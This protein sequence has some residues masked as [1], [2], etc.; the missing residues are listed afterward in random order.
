[1]ARYLLV[2]D[3]DRP[4][5]SIEGATFQR[6]GKVFAIR[7]HNVPTDKKR[8]PQTGSRNKFEHVQTRFR[9]LSSIEKES[10]ADEAINYPRTDSLGNEYVLS[11]I[12]LQNSSNTNLINA[13]QPVINTMPGPVVFP[14][15]DVNNIFV[16]YAFNSA[17]FELNTAF[18]PAGFSLFVFSAVPQSPG[19]D[20]MLI[21]SLKL[22]K[23]FP[24]GGDT[25]AN[26]FTDYIAVFGANPYPVGSKVFGAFQF[27]S[28]DTGQKSEIVYHVGEV[29]N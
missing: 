18:V 26:I 28:N 19:V 5:G 9:N 16:R 24:A 4:R 12:N 22:F 8:I 13:G 2:E 29:E 10:F 21:N 20:S 1:M 25:S 3:V 15:L 11:A 14:S 17:E 27:M 23:I 7:K 6:C